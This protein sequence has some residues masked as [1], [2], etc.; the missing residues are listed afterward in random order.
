MFKKV[1]FFAGLI[2]SLAFS[3]AYGKN[4]TRKTPWGWDIE[5]VGEYVFTYNFPTNVVTSEN[6]IFVLTNGAT[7]YQTITMYDKNLKELFQVQ[8]WKEKPSEEA[9]DSANLILPYQSFYQGMYYKDNKLYVAGGFSDNILVFD[10]YPNSLK[11]YKRIYLKAQKIPNNQYPYTYQG[12]RYTERLFYPDA[13]IKGNKYIYATGLLANSIARIDEN[14]GTIDYLNV[15]AYPNNIALSSKYIFVS[16]WG[17]N[18]VAVLDRKDFSLVKT[19][20]VGKILNKYSESAGVHPIDLYYKNGKLFV[21]LANSGQIA[22]INTDDLKVDG[23]L[24]DKLFEDQEPGSYPDSLFEDNG[25]LFV[26]SAGTNSINV[27]DIESKKLIGAIPTGWYPSAM[28]KDSENIYVVSAKGVG[29]T[30][31]PKS[32]WVGTIMPGILQ[33]VSFD[34]IKDN[35]ANY[36]EDVF[37]NDKFD[38]IVKQK[39]VVDFLRKHIKYVVFILRENKT[40]DEDFG[41]YKKAGKWA[42]P[43]LAFYTKKELPNLFNFANNYVLMANFYADGE[44]TAQA[45]QWNTGANDSDFV[46]R[47]WQE[48]YS[49]RGLIENPGYLQSLE[50][51]YST[52]WG[53]MPNGIANPYAVYED[54]SKLGKWTNPW[55]S[56]PYKLYLFNNLLSHH[57]SFEDFGE[58]VSRNRWGDI[59]KAMKPHIAYS[60]P[61]WDRFIL[62][63][64]RANVAI[65][66]FKHHKMPHFSYIWLPDDH[67]A[68]LQPCYYTPDYYVANNDYATAKIIQYLS[69][70]PYWKNMAI[71]ITE[72]DAQSGADHIDAH[73][74]FAVIV[75]PWVKSGYISTKHYSQVNITKTIEKILGIPPMSIFD[76]TASVIS[77][78]W[79]SKPNFSTIEA[80]KPNVKLAFNKGYC[81]NY[82]LLR[83][84]VGAAGH[85]RVNKWL[86]QHNMSN[87]N[88]NHIYIP[89]SKNLYTPT[90]LLKVS[91]FEQFKQTAIATKGYDGYLK[92]IDYIKNM[93]KEE[94]KSIWAFISN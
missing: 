78:I 7:K 26:S 63:T 23:F 16:L 59:P 36:E 82:T 70:T 48:Y 43:N 90:A 29:S 66:W 1:L 33:K 44:V 74:T 15:G 54:L 2:F 37:K 50:L 10:V 58:F 39:T 65:N 42:D 60:F 73:R 14:K 3:L 51:G 76:Q 92:M 11:L 9:E 85:Y 34:D 57:V 28:T 89:S 47:T 8:A 30:P 80:I 19:I 5:P 94:H 75:S 31:N 64:Y 88:I 87:N 68:G 12:A 41:T 61:G 72:D 22:M 6:H 49:N 79:S 21:S 40:F 45:H 84:E 38:N 67:A 69:H 20:E 62:D 81:P 17:S 91:G 93:S 35:L 56:Y 77:D 18:A 46:E 71:F 32:Q 83:R 52:G 13:V 25:K 55:I 24:E 53:G 86:K 27:F 4:Y